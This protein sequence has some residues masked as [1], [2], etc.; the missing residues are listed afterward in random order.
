MAET[1]LQGAMLTAAEAARTLGVSARMVYALFKAGK[2]AGYKIGRAIRFA[3]T[4]VEDFKASC[5][6]VGARETSGGGLTSTATFR[7]AATGLCDSFRA[8]GVKPKLTP[9]T[10]RKARASTRLQL[11]Y[12][13]KT[14]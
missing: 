13:D 14:T 11:A 6:S 7:A 5:R 8:A 2:L 4:D 12:S 9:T 10:G 1:A 3:E